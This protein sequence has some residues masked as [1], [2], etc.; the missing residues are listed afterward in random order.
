MLVPWV[1]LKVLMCHDL[2]LTSIPV[3]SWGA[4]FHRNPGPWD[5]A[6]RGPV[7]ETGLPGIR[8]S[9]PSCRMGV[10]QS[11]PTCGP[12]RQNPEGRRRIDHSGIVS[13]IR[14]PSQQTGSGIHS[15][16]CYCSIFLV[17]KGH[18]LQLRSWD[19]V[20]SM[21]YFCLLRVTTPSSLKHRQDFALT[22]VLFY[23]SITH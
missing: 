17:R 5:C 20:D 11:T 4:N 15:L 1:G 10:W 21:T 3:A 12:G 13:N 7:D 2:E 23:V 18:S 19:N 8:W 6:S 22:I 14:T 9:P 16:D